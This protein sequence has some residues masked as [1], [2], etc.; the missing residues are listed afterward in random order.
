[1][2]TCN[3]AYIVPNIIGDDCRVPGV[4]FWDPVNDFSHQVGPHIRGFR[5]NATTDTAE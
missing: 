2:N 4:I 1:M 5:I 3:I